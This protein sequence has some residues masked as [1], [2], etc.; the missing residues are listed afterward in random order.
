MESLKKYNSYCASFQERKKALEEEQAKHKRHLSVFSSELE[1]A[2]LLQDAGRIAKAQAGVD[3]L[4]QRL[5]G[6]KEELSETDSKPLAEQ[7]LLE[8]E[9]L[10]GQL[11]QAVQGQWQRAREKRIEFLRELEEL[12]RLRR[13]SAELSWATQSAMRDLNRNPLSEIRFGVNRLEFLVSQELVDK[14]LR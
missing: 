11:N 5:S 13:Q 7:V 8:S 2:S 10:M 9:E 1:T 3:L 12:G 6:V 14:Y 4:T